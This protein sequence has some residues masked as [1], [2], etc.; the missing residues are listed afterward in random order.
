MKRNLIFALLALL[1]G[2]AAGLSVFFYAYFYP[3]LYVKDETGTYRNI[4]AS[5]EHETF[6]VTS[7][8][9]IEVEHYFPDE[10]RTLTE[11]VD[12]FPQL[13]GCDRDGV[14]R[15]LKEY[16]K[17]PSMEDR[18]KGLQSYELVSYH[19]NT[20]CL[21]KTYQ[22][23]VRKGF[24]AKSFNGTVVI[25]RGDEKTVYEYTQISISLLPEQLQAEVMEGY[26]MEDE[27]ALYNFLETYSS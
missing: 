14:E 5:A 20:V 19:D 22:K 8:T 12:D 1:I 16:L 26:Y 18:E 4:T 11:R 25:M 13:L 17:H 23:E 7:R 2:A 9:V 6:P 10:N 21:R 3:K 24:F 15:Y 27:R